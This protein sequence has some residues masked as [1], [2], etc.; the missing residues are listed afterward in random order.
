VLA[1]AP[2]KIQKAGPRFAGPLSSTT[3]HTGVSPGGEETVRGCVSG[4]CHG[5]RLDG[6]VL[7][8]ITRPA[9]ARKRSS[10][11]CGA[12]RRRFHVTL[13]AQEVPGRQE[14]G[15]SAAQS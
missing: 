13:G 11:R 2:S 6:L 8:T 1:K 7:S 15:I 5:F 4:S 14:K 12:A 9:M 3:S 10:R